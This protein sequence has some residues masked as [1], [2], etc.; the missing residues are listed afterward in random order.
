MPSK[1]IMETYI[2][3]QVKFWEKQ[4]EKIDTSQ[5]KKEEVKKQL[6]FITISRE[7]GCGAYEIGK[8]LAD[9]LNE[10]SAGT[11]PWAAYD[12]ELLEKIMNDMGISSSLAETLTNNAKKALT[13]L[14]QTSF[15]KFPSQVT[16]YKKL[17]E[18]E[19]LL[20]TNGKVIL[21]GRAGNVITKDMEKGYNVRIVADKKW[22]VNRL[23]ALMK[24][25]EKEAEKIIDA[26]DKERNLFIKEYVKFDVTDPHHYHLFINVARH[27][28]KE[29][30]EIIAKGLEKKGFI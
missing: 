14:L 26:K 19:R 16:I 21:I 29:V 2:N 23:A 12:K 17:V 6:P 11:P 27:T 7:Y 20:A 24:I 1:N 25:K 8:K 28:E 13:N 18:T 10:K 5:I 30:A 4:K 3:G 22:K 15:S 9:F